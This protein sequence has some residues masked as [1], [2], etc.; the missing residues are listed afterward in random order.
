MSA[1]IQNRAHG[2]APLRTVDDFHR[3]RYN[4]PSL[5][6]PSPA[7]P[8]PHSIKRPGPL[9]G[10]GLLQLVT[11]RKHNETEFPKE[12]KEKIEQSGYFFEQSIVNILKK[13]E[14]G[15]VV[16]NYAYKDPEEGTSRE[17]DSFLITSETISEGSP[18]YI[19]PVLLIEA[20]KI[21]LVCFTHEEI[22]SPE[23]YE[24][25]LSGI[26]EMIQKGSKRQTLMEF[27]RVEKFHHYYKRK[28]L[29]TQFWSPKRSDARESE[30][31]YHRKNF[32]IPIVKALVAEKT[33]HLTG[34][35]FDPDGEPINLQFYYPIIVVENLWECNLG[36]QRPKF[37]RLSQ[38][39]FMKRYKSEKISGDFFIDLCDK[40]GLLDLL[41]DI[42]REI[43]IVRNIIKKSKTIVENSAWEEAKERAKIK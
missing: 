23:I 22:I 16:S 18:H 15:F 41:R 27:L 13:K 30:E 12:W 6:T 40:N 37:K 8:F 10:E 29:A 19:F 42:N 1:L 31:E 35:Y 9:G 34:W 28:R 14:Y 24:I 32:T 5:Y 26:P 21:D 2:R 39:G 36:Q 43:K 17:L 7:R 11:M 20:K 3:T 4:P 25:H 33:E 38:V